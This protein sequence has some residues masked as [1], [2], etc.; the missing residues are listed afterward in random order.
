MFLRMPTPSNSSGW[1]L[2]GPLPP[3]R[4]ERRIVAT[5]DQSVSGVQGRYASALLE[6]AREENA[7]EAVGQQLKAFGEAIER[8][9][10]LKRLVRSPVFSSDE[11]IAAIDGVARDIGVTGIALN[12]LKLVAG[13]RRLSAL[14][15]IISAYGTLLA[16]S[17]GEIAGEAISAEPLSPQQ[18]SDLKAALKD[19]LGRDV[20]LTTRVD[21][22]ILGG[23]IVKVGSR[24]LDNSLKTKLQSLKTA[25]KGTA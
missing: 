18:L 1:R 9:D 6:L 17:K 14:P 21:E 25:M 23:L 11:Q 3:E 15:G 7:A 24:M 4:N 12:F 20:A 5:T 8:S 13:K 10:D 19:S 22:S 16:G 2:P